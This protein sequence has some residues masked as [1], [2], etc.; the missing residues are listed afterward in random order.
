MLDGQ[1]VLLVQLLL[2]VIVKVLKKL[3]DF[4]PEWLEVFVMEWFEDFSC[5]ETVCNCADW[6]EI[7]LVILF[8]L[9]KLIID[10]IFFKLFQMVPKQIQI[11]YLPYLSMSL[12]R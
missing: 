11:L 9:P 2:F 6:A 5:Q 12:E 4:V 3:C 7:L 8:D 1:K 10:Q